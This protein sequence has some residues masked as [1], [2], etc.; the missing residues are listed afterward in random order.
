MSPAP[1]VTTIGEDSL[2]DPEVVA[3]DSRTPDLY[4]EST[5]PGAVNVPYSQAVDRL[6][7]L[8]CEIDFK[9]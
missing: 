2:A 6:G 3:I 7:E 4:L 9:G 8:G 1:G 5:I